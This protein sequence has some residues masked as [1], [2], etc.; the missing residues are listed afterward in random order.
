MRFSPS[1][2]AQSYELGVTN[3]THV[4]IASRRHSM[5]V[6]FTLAGLP[7]RSVTIE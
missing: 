5:Y 4:F 7:S 1:I 6:Q 3:A 2:V